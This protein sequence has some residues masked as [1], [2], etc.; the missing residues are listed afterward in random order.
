M[1]VEHKVV[2]VTG[3]GSGI[4]AAIARRFA[5]EG[6]R[7]I[8]VVDLN[9]AAAEAVAVEI[10][11][12]GLQADVASE[13]ELLRIIEVAQARFGPID[14]FCSNAGT[15]AI[16]GPEVADAAWQRVWEV[17]VM[18]HVYVAR[19]LVPAMLERG[20]G[21]LLQTASA[22]GLLSQFDAPYAVTKHAAVAFSEWLAMTYGS[23]GVRVS[24]LCPG[25]VDTPMFRAETAARQHLLGEGLL[26]ADNVADAVI[27][28]LDAERFLI[29]P[30]PWIA[31]LMR[32]KAD[33]PDRWLRGMARLH[34]KARTA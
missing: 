14:L 32:R 34:D 11:G 15:T 10:G 23:R 33:D 18:A 20:H 13:L 31:D 28:G 24:C 1:R 7:A 26:S 22:A 8:V 25:G 19:A 5:R 12:L 2:V 17:N 6:A 27:E 30:Q 16:G 21:Y 3:A 29:L 9:G 4:G